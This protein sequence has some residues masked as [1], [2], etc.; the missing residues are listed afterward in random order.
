MERAMPESL[1]VAPPA[2]AALER[3]VDYAGLFPPAQLAMEPAVAQYRSAVASAQS[4]MLGRYVVPVARL[5]E[6]E[7]ALGTGDPV[8]AVV[9]MDMQT[10]VRPTPHVTPEAC[11]VLL[12]PA[13]DEIGALRTAV[14]ALRKGLENLAPGIPVAVELPR[15]LSAALL[16]EGVDVLAESGYALKIRCGGVTADMTPPVDEVTH[17]VRA[18]SHAH[19]AIKATAGLHHPVRHFNEEAGFVMHGFLNVL[20]AVCA[21]PEGDVATVSEIVAEEDAS[22][23]CFDARGFTWRGTMLAA[24]DRLHALRRHSFLGFGSC[25]FSEPVEDL[26]RMGILP[27]A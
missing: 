13:S 3:I 5:P 20:A 17:V 7:S 9:L 6:L 26:T 11:E 27:P 12:R 19:V 14:R 15:R 1:A 16:A 25:S 8:A 23:F 22:A 10:P 2:R 21:A 18:A 4:W 24:T